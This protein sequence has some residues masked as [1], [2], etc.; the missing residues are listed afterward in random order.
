[1]RLFIGII[2]F[3]IILVSCSDD[4]VTN[5][6]EVG[7]DFLDNTTTIRVLDTFT[8]NTGTFKQEELITSGTNAFL[9]G[10]IKDDVL[11]NLTA[12]PYF[13]VETTAANFALIEND[14]RFDSIGFVMNFN[15]Y[16]EGDTL[17]QQTY[18]LHQIIEEVDYDEDETTFFNHSSLDFD[19][20]PIGQIT[21]TPKPTKTTDSLYI[22]INY[23]KGLELFTK[24]QEGEIEDSN[25]FFNAFEGLTIV[26]EVNNSHIL[27]FNVENT[28]STSGSTYMR[29]YYTPDD[30]S[31]DDENYMDFV[32]TEPNYLFNSFTTDDQIDSNLADILDDSEI[33]I[34]SKETENLT[35]LQA[36]SGIATRIDLP[37]LK[38][39]KEISSLGSVLN[40]ELTFK[41]STTSF[42]NSDDLQDELTI[43]IIDNDNNII[44]TAH[45]TA[46]L[47]DDD[48]SE[49][50]SNTFYTV[51]LTDFVDLIVSSEVDLEYSLMIQFQ[52]NESTAE[53]TVIDWDSDETKL[54]IKYLNY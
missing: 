47:N 1:M 49:F 27:G 31:T 48:N 14:T 51:D 40:A 11:G 44:I 25:D 20:S 6:Y 21:I 30:N 28:E 3:F 18:K 43:N 23:D 10:S 13:R 54:S 12:Q 45:A 33:T 53:R 24:I 17:R 42:D 4:Q 15:S 7:S 5:N 26:P 52:N 16:Y 8:I 9:L 50:D 37:S 29:L 22:P 32:I 41:P 39:I 35:Y 2:T 38:K 19:S 46:F 36:G 34:S